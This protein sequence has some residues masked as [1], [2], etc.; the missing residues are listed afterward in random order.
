M[1]IK[2]LE[3]N[4]KRLLKKC[5]DMAEVRDEKNWRFEKVSSLNKI[6][7]ENTNN[8]STSFIF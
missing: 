7:A 4:F 2:H 8:N 1:D 3:I 6:Q 5:E